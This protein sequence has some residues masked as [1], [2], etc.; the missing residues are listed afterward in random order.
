MSSNW[1]MVGLFTL[2]GAEEVAAIG[3]E[4][5]KGEARLLVSL[6]SK[7]G[8]FVWCDVGAARSLVKLFLLDDFSLL[9]TLAELYL[10]WYLCF[11]SYQRCFYT[12]YQHLFDVKLVIT[13]CFVHSSLKIGT[14]KK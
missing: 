1:M 8:A 5:A 12:F 13:F 2:G 10:Y 6:G 9:M 4:I 3:V 14:K 7:Y 11:S